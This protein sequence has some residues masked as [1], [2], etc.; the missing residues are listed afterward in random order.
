[1]IMK[2]SKLLSTAVPLFFALVTTVNAAC[3]ESY[4]NLEFSECNASDEHTW[5]VNPEKGSKQPGHCIS[6]SLAERLPL[7][8]CGEVSVAEEEMLRKDMRRFLQDP[9]GPFDPHDPDPDEPH[10]KPDGPDDPDEPDDDP[11]DPDQPDDRDLPGNDKVR[12]FFRCITRR[13]LTCRQSYVCAP[14]VIED[15]CFS[16]CLP[17]YFYDGEIF[18]DLCQTQTTMSPE[19]SQ[20]PSLVEASL[21]DLKVQGCVAHDTENLCSQNK[22]DGDDSCIWCGGELDGVCLEASVVNDVELCKSDITS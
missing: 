19:A 20:S 9:D 12:D 21:D 17:K 10:G 22:G 5:C 11:D 16:I 14:C 8:T 6:N 4:L 18:E 15:G 7:G 3:D 1:V 2:L 13:E